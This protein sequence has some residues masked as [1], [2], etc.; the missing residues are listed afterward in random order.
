MHS[1]NFLKKLPPERTVFTSQIINLCTQSQSKHEPATQKN[2]Q[3][4]SD[5][6]YTKYFIYFN[7]VPAMILL[8][9]VHKGQRKQKKK[10]GD[11]FL[12]VTLAEMYEYM[13]ECLARN[14]TTRRRC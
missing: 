9:V 14:S 13:G 10:F 5:K 2:W 8:C 7:T 6:K 12:H 4:C 11:I 3:N 1:F